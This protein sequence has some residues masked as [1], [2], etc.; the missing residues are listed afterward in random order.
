MSTVGRYRHELTRAQIE[1]V[2]TIAGP[3]M[4]RYGYQLGLA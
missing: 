3:T 2:E 1:E 4:V